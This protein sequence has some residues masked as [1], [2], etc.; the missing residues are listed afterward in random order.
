MKFQ[1]YYNGSNYKSIHH[2]QTRLFQFV[3]NIIIIIIRF[4][5]PRFYTKQ[6]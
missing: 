3:V 4:Y 6:V 2:E 1:T 5:L